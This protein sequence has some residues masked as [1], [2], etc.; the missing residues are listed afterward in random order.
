MNALKFCLDLGMN[1]RFRIE[2]PFMQ[3]DKTQTRELTRTLGCNK[4]TAGHVRQAHHTGHLV[5]LNSSTSK[6]ASANRETAASLQGLGAMEMR[7]SRCALIWAAPQGLCLHHLPGC[8]C[9]TRRYACFI[10]RIPA[11]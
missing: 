9:H 8:E 5:E 1:T 7:I 2:T 3:K 4:T 11:G 10:Q 6:P